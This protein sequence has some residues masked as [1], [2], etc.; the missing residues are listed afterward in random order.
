MKQTKKKSF[1]LFLVLILA[2]SSGVFDHF[3]S[4]QTVQAAANV[5]L[6]KTSTTLHVGNTYTL[7]LNGAKFWKVKWSSSK[8]DIAK[9][10]SKGMVTALKR[11][12]ASITAKYNNKSYKCKIIVKSASLSERSLCLRVGYGYPVEVVNTDGKVSWSSSNEKVASIN[13]N[14]YISPLSIG[15]TK[16]TAKVGMETYSC[17][18]NVVEYFTEDDFVFDEPDDEGYTNFIDY[19]T[20][21][22][23]SWYWYWKD[24]AEIYSCNRGINIGNTYEDFIAAYGYSESSAVT[25]NDKYKEVFNNSAYPRT[26]VELDYKDNV[27]QNHY[28]KKFYFDKNGTVVLIIWHR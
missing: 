3:V 11:G 19:S 6:N 9:V 21:K 28:Y 7:K 12:N 1:I 24:A 20:G 8:P 10:S 27:T 25:T 14:G 17:L 4:V 16:I 15:K 26:Y 5:K 2:C 13:S 22:G 18:L 23:S